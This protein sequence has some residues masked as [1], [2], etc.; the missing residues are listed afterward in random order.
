MSPAGLDAHVNNT[1]KSRVL[2]EFDTAWMPIREVLTLPSYVIPLHSLILTQNQS[3][4]VPSAGS[5]RRLAQSRRNTSRDFLPPG[6][7]ADELRRGEIGSFMLLSGDVPFVRTSGTG[8]HTRVHPALLHGISTP[9]S[10]DHTTHTMRRLQT[11]ADVDP[12]LMVA[13]PALVTIAI[14]T[15]GAGW[16]LAGTIAV[17]VFFAEMCQNHPEA[18]DV[19]FLRSARAVNSAA[20]KL[21]D[22]VEAE[23]ASLDQVAAGIQAETRMFKL[24]TQRMDATKEMIS[25]LASYAKFSF[26]T[27]VTLLQEISQEMYHISLERTRVSELLSDDVDIVRYQL[28]LERYARAHH[29]SVLRQKALTDLDMTGVALRIQQI[30]G[31]RLMIE[32]TLQHQGLQPEIAELCNVEQL[33]LW[34]TVLKQE[35]QVIF[36]SY[37]RDWSLPHDRWTIM[38]LVCNVNY[39]YLLT[40]S[41]YAGVN[42]LADY[43]IVQEEVDCYEFP[44]RNWT[45]AVKGRAYAEIPTYSTPIHARLSA[46]TYLKELQLRFQYENKQFDAAY[47]TDFVRSGA[48]LD[49]STGTL[50]IGAPH[51]RPAPEV[52]QLP[53]GALIRCDGVIDTTTFTFKSF[54]EGGDSVDPCTFLDYFDPIVDVPDRIRN[55]FP[56]MQQKMQNVSRMVAFL[57]DYDGPVVAACYGD[58]VEFISMEA[59]SGIQYEYR[60]MENYTVSEFS[61]A[62]HSFR[63]GRPRSG[64]ISKLRPVRNVGS[65]L[66]ASNVHQCPV[67]NL[68]DDTLRA[69]AAASNATSP[70]GTDVNAS[71]LSSC[72]PEV[73]GVS[74][75]MVSCSEGMVGGLYNLQLP[76]HELNLHH[77]SSWVMDTS[78]SQHWDYV[79]DASSYR[80][81]EVDVSLIHLQ[82][83]VEIVDTREDENRLAVFTSHMREQYDKKAATYREKMERYETNLSTLRL[84]WDVDK[85]AMRDAFA[86]AS[87]LAAVAAVKLEETKGAI[88]EAANIIRNDWGNYSAAA[89]LKLANLVKCDMLDVRCAVDQFSRY[90]TAYNFYRTAV[91]I[92]NWLIVVGIA[93]VALY[94]LDSFYKSNMNR[95]VVR[96]GI[97]FALVAVVSTYALF[98]ILDLLNMTLVVG[99]S[100]GVIAILLL[101]GAI[102]HI[103]RGVDMTTSVMFKLI[104]FCLASLICI[105]LFLY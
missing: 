61:N 42:P 14:V 104:L 20:G 89:Q 17:G 85:S 72:G 13:T 24:I 86:N 28:Q 62:V 94:A 8:Y 18:A 73:G 87:V 41:A 52:K 75:V 98:I 70:D 101:L 22:S 31:L 29:R 81:S 21:R 38:G 53:P 39:T 77:S 96:I 26:E 45:F 60:T 16:I 51:L 10:Q 30:R 37:Y 48:E 69:W 91:I 50:K 82:L 57:I 15:G 95:R 11:L 44:L 12:V 36:H 25:S 78:S 90:R 34:P 80:W 88:R 43:V 97:M 7:I 79:A 68:T 100:V 32:H 46:S 99:V 35:Q 65:S 54:S 47:V 84:S 83:N 4:V 19:K 33:N 5:G 40:D 58:L 23:A 71:I 92:L 76:S 6:A 66:D 64:Y 2:G 102:T 27:T 3:N 63:L 93:F 74:K 105:V 103:I 56:V 59:S 9:S 55:E 1:K 67:Q 49:A